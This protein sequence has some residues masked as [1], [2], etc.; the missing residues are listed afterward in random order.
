MLGTTGTDRGAVEG[1]VQVLPPTPRER[2]RSPIITH[3]GFESIWLGSVDQLFGT[4][5]DGTLE[6]HA[7][8]WER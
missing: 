7:V 5:H 8:M 4:V 3:A 6:A 1:G 2:L